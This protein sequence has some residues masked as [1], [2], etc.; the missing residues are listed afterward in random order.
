V[1]HMLTCR[2]ADARIAA[3]ADDRGARLDPEFEAHLASCERCQERLTANREVRAALQAR[4]PV[5]VPAGFTAR[6]LARAAG[7]E[8]A[9]NW[10]ALVDWQQWTKWV[11]PVTAALVLG[12]TLS[13][14]LVTDAAG[15]ATTETVTAIQTPATTDPAEAALQQDVSSDELI[16]RMLGGSAQ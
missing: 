6:V 13:G 8:R 14:V 16:A 15:T 7:R 11:L 12:A 2:T 3:A 4:P 1:R 9:D 5:S 10:L